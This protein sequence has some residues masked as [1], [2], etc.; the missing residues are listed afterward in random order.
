[1]GGTLLPFSS[2]TEARN[3]SWA[4]SNFVPAPPARLTVLTV[5]AIYVHLLYMPEFASIIITPSSLV[6]FE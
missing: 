3:R 5:G 4:Q 1:M 6:L 2:A